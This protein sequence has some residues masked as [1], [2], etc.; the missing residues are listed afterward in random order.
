MHPGGAELYIA[1]HCWTDGGEN[2]AFFWVQEQERGPCQH[3]HW[4]SHKGRSRARLILASL[5]CVTLVHNSPDDLGDASRWCGFNISPIIVGWT[6]GENSSAFWVH[7]SREG[8]AGTVVGEVHKIS[9]ALTPILAS[10]LRLRC[11]VS[12]VQPGGAELYIAYHW[13][14]DGGNSAVFGCTRARGSGPCRHSHW[15]VRKIRVRC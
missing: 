11:A 8:H 12:A 13:V 2:S 5:H 7:K 1:Y 14:E 10:I 6:D 15:R 3:S 9:R 4:R